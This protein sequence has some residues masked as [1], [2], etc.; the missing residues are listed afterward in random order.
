[1]DYSTD[2]FNKALLFAAKAHGGQ[3]IDGSEIPYIVH[4]V[5]VA[6]ELI[7]FFNRYPEED[8]NLLIQAALL[9]DVLEDTF[10]SR[11]A[12]REEFGEE[13]EQ[14]VFLLSKRVIAEDMEKSPEEYLDELANGSKSAQIVKLADRIVNLNPPPAG[15]SQKRISD[16]HDESEEIYRKLHLA[17]QALADRLKQKIKHYKNQFIG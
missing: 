17:N 5:M 9:H 2:A 12:L 10:T 4:P 1:L 11:T 8:P 15:W 6:S 13:V 3:K 7:S 16:Y 14:H